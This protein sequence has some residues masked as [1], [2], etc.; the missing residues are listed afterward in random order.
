[1]ANHVEQAEDVLAWSSLTVRAITD[2][3][4][5]S[6]A[7]VIDLAERHPCVRRVLPYAR[8]LSQTG[9]RLRRRLASAGPGG[10]RASPQEGSVDEEP[11]GDRRLVDSV[12]G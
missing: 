6:K 2:A 1:M 8:R 9:R 3:P 12:R 7:L 4:R 10:L 11:R 5:W